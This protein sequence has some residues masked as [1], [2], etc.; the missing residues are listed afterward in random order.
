MQD[1]DGSSKKQKTMTIANE[2]DRLV[3]NAPTDQAHLNYA[4]L[5]RAADP[6]RELQMKSALCACISFLPD[7]AKD[8]VAQ[9]VMALT[10]RTLAPHAVFTQWLDSPLFFLKLLLNVGHE[11]LTNT[12][13]RSN[14]ATNLFEMFYRCARAPILLNIA[15]QT[16]TQEFRIK[17]PTEYTPTAVWKKFVLAHGEHLRRYFTS[18]QFNSQTNESDQ[19]L[20]TLLRTWIRVHRPQWIG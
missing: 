1:A 19:I 3:C 16:I 11:L 7:V 9:Y 18:L 13:L 5:S 14:S 8:I 17:S 12:E 6:S 20:L 10:L 15:L 4:Q 2:Y